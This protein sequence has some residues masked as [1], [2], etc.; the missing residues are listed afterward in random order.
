MVKWFCGHGCSHR[1]A[2][3][4]P[5]TSINDAGQPFSPRVAFVAAT[6]QPFSWRVASMRALGARGLTREDTTCC[7]RRRN[8]SPNLGS[9]WVGADGSIRLGRPGETY[10]A[11]PP[12]RVD[13]I[14]HTRIRWIDPLKM[15]AMVPFAKPNHRRRSWPYEIGSPYTILI[16]IRFSMTIT[17]GYTYHRFM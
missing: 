9:E 14:G 12:I 15:P 7:P 16:F 3:C 8:G 17:V 5:A 10:V 2:F 6:G 11:Y 13:R 1:S 4:H